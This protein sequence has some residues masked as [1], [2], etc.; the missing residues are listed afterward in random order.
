MKSKLFLILAVLAFVPVIVL[1]ANIRA[2][3]TTGNITYNVDNTITLKEPAIN[4][5]IKSNSVA[6]NFSY[7]DTAITFTLAPGNQVVIESPDKRNFTV[8]NS[9]VTKTFVCGTNVSTLTLSVNSSGASQSVTIT[10]TSA[11]CDGTIPEP[12]PTPTTCTD[13]DGGKDYYNKGCTTYSIGSGATEEVCDFCRNNTLQEYYCKVDQR[14]LVLYQCPNGCKDGACLLKGSECP[15]IVPLNK[16][17]GCTYTPI[18]NDANGCV[19][20]YNE[21]CCTNHTYNTCPSYCSKKCLPSVCS[22]N[23]CTTDCEGV[24]SCYYLSD[25]A[26]TTEYNAVCG[27][28]GKTYSNKCHLEKDGV[29]LDY[30]GKCQETTCRVA[31]ICE[32]GY[33]PKNTG[34]KDSSG[35]PIMKCISKDGNSEIDALRR[36]IKDLKQEIIRIKQE[37]LNREKNLVQ[38]IDKVLTRRLKGRILLQVEEKGEAWYVSPIDEN[39]YY[40][41]RPSDAFD[42]MRKLGLGVSEKDYNSFNGIAPAKLSGRILLRVQS[43]G[44]AY[45]V[46]PIDLKMHYLGRPA[47]AFNIMRGK[48][49]G[50]TNDNLRKIEVGETTN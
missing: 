12:I 17:E 10:P 15:S 33:L 8:S 1:S 40:L 27:K 36:E 30:Y 37:F 44:E 11:T 31:A 45:Y 48:G 22:G 9:A 39:K 19:T 3:T 21:D 32:A 5:I 7:G 50:I 16:R 4:L 42:V 28:D 2:A 6:N 38:K 13:S 18:R 49:L 20:G 43:K 24:G 47:D 35:C 29:Q 14:D 46:N 34:E 25:T 26:C 23:K 41:G